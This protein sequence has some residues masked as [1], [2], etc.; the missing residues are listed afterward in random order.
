[1]Q[2]Q[3]GSVN[4]IE[5]PSFI[6]KS[7]LMRG[8]HLG[9]VGVPNKHRDEIERLHLND[10]DPES[11][12]PLLRRGSSEGSVVIQHDG[13]KIEAILPRS[14]RVRGKGSNEKAVYTS[15]LSSHPKTNLYGA[16][17]DGVGGNDFR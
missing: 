4:I 7:S 13:G 17:F 3:S 1:M 5:G 8:V 11:R 9:L 14:G 2:L 15:M 10:T 12:A 6:G 16:V